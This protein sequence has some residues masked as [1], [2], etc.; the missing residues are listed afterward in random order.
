M[1]Q[2]VLLIH[3]VGEQRPMDTLRSFVRTVWTT[4]RGVQ[5]NHPDGAGVWSKPYTL[6]ENFELRRLT[7]AENRAGIRTD[8][9]ELYWA[10]LMRGTKIAHVVGWAK[11]LLLRKPSTVPV[12]LRL[13]YW[14]A[15]GLLAAGLI[16]AYLSAAAK[17]A[18]A[19]SPPV[20]ARLTLSL[21]I[22]PAVMGVL[23]NV[24]GDAARYLNAAPPN[25]GCRR[26]IRSMGVRVLQSLHQ[27]GYDRIIVV[28]HSL[29]SVIGYDILNF[30]W[31]ACNAAAP[32]ADAPSYAALNTLESLAVAEDDGKPLVAP[33]FRAAQ[34]AY[35]DELKANGS[36][37]RVTDFITLGSPLAHA[38]ILL[39]HD[40]TDLASKCAL[41]ELPR[42]PPALESS[43]H[44]G[45]TLKRFSYPPTQTARTPHQAAVFAPTRWTNLYFPCHALVRGDLVG[46]PLQPVLGAGILDIPVATSLWRGFLSHT[47]YWD[48]DNGGSRHVVLLRAVLDLLDENPTTLPD[49][50]AESTSAGSVTQ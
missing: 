48:M 13:P 36:L 37:W 12:H 32:T 9:F 46:G 11:T 4:D 5:R 43:R 22:I 23:L 17:A 26:A 33:T 8:F 38:A 2:A 50:L 42:C 29:G 44:Q 41:R 27:R 21:L 15:W 28:G 45:G 40:A 14:T 20:W 49:T 25:V 19:S 7:T 18:G 3:G 34:R 30:T 31:S 35:F 39:A 10:H 47:H 1:K 16:L 24:V 6:E